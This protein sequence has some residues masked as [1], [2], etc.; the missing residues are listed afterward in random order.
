[1]KI[2]VV[3]VCL[4]ASTALWAQEPW[5]LHLTCDEEVELRLNLYEEDINVPGMDL[6]GKMNGYL[7]GK[8][9]GVWPITSF[10]ILSD[11]EAT[12]RVS[13]DLGSETQALRLTC[14]TDS[15]WTLQ[16]EGRNV[17]RKVE[18]K[19]LVKVPSTYLMR[20]K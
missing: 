15:T 14:Q 10:K 1:M 16:L 12:L 9:Y 3:F 19:K 6:F 11:K 8:I 5:R 17:I 2:F 7:G 13:N 4:M 18:G 20:R